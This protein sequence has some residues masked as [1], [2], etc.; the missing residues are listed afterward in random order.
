MASRTSIQMPGPP[1]KARFVRFQ[2][3][4]D[5]PTSLGGDGAWAI[6]EDRRGNLWVGTE[7]GLDKLEP[8][9]GRFTHYREPDGLPNNSVVCIQEDSQ[10]NLWLSTNNGLVRLNPI[11]MRFR[12]YDVSHGLQSNEFDSGACLRSRNGE[13]Y[14]GGIAGFNV[15]RP[16]EIRENPAPPPV[17]I[18]G[19][20]IF[21]QPAPIDL[22]GATPVDLSYQENF[23]AF[24]FAALDYH[25]PK[26]N[27]Y[28]YQLEGFDTEWQDAGT[29]RYAAYTNL[30]GGRYVFHVRGSN[31]DGVWN[32]AGVSIPLTVAPPI[33]ET[34]WF[35]SIVIVLAAML[36]VGGYW[37]RV[38]SIRA[39]NLRLEHKVTLQ[40]AALRREIEQRKQAE[41]ALAQTA[42][43]E[44]VVAERTRLARELHDAV[45]QTLF[46]ASLIAEVLPELYATDVAEGQRSSDELRQLTRGA[47]AEMRTLLLE[48]RPSAVTKAQLT[49]LVRQLIEATTGRGRVP[50][51]FNTEGQRNLPDDV[52]VAFYRIAQE[53]LNN[54][55][56]YAKAKQVIVDLRQQP[57][58]VRLTI[59]DD[60]LGF[61]PEAVGPGHHGQRIMRERAETIGARLAVHSEVGHGTLI[62]LTWRDPAWSEPVTPDVELTQKQDTQNSGGEAP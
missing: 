54:V 47:L 59:G 33:W 36:L 58:G 50:V 20:R 13:L 1:G 45:T 10:G 40:T 5:D 6:H 42:A 2:H 11:L 30:P 53:A 23:V 52:K 35:R 28:A 22:T 8:A 43:N 62:T 3:D 51:Q 15:F 4:P 46:S 25:A 16:G 19:F 26:K 29:R 61:D 9:T 49:D 37:W 60:G 7:N 56:K 44:A 27:H 14:F 31:S 12:T 32:E 41:A 39:Q 18:T 38:S 48:L 57:M 34:V 21:N 17:V 55:V 24:D